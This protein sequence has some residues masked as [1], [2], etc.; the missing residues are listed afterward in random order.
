LAGEPRCS[1]L[2][3][4]E[5]GRTANTSSSKTDGIF[6]WTCALI[7]DLLGPRHLGEEIPSQTEAI[8]YG[9]KIRGMSYKKHRFSNLHRL[10]IRGGVAFSPKKRKRTNQN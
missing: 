5:I 8:H 7:E 6:G 2:G 4:L 9:S 1:S 10:Q 3:I